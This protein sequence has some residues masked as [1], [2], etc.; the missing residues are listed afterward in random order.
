MTVRKLMAGAGAACIALIAMC[1]SAQASTVTLDQLV[2][3]YAEQRDFSGVVLVARDGKPLY[4]AAFGVAQ[5]GWTTPLESDAVFRIGSL[6]KP[7]TATLVMRLA[8]LG[9]IDLDQTV[10]FYLP[11]LYAET[12]A[13]RIT[14]RQLL[15]HTSG[16][17]DVAPRYTDPFWTSAARRSY[18]PTEFAREW[19]PGKLAGKPGV[20]RYNNNGYFLLGMI[21]EAATGN[22]YADNLRQHILQ[23][24][25]MRDSGV[26]DGRSILPKLALATAPADDGGRQLPPYIDASVSYA[27]AGVYGSAQD[28]LR[29][30][31]ALADGRLLSQAA[32]RE[33]FMDRGNQ[34]G[35]GWGVE[36]WTVQGGPARPVVT[37]TGSIPGYQSILVRSV[38]DRVTIIILNNAWQGA[39]VVG[40]ARDIADQLH[41]KPVALPKR[42]LADALT[43][44]LYHQGLDAMRAEYTRL[45]ASEPENYDVSEKALNAFG[46]GLLR[47]QKI[48][49]AV[50][51]MRWNAAA[52]PASPNVHDSLAETLLAAGDVEG[53]RAGYTRV[54]ALDPG[55]RHAAAELQKLRP[56]NP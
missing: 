2:R 42:S 54:L 34:Y 39:V 32:Q 23:P 17:A 35:Y 31:T 12:E 6:S 49:A 21:I 20:W 55:N 1:A 41:G 18:T 14:L 40:M 38:S 4:Q 48:E 3:G 45:R 33:M 53:A 27:A 5:P 30:D 43:P 29:F 11:A 24:A 15:S 46:Y 10:G 25:G 47:K 13:G 50:Q 36:D 28:L 56:A 16:L 19:I 22:S 9:R 37:H 7:M 26:F 44:I 8:E 52:Y 51:V